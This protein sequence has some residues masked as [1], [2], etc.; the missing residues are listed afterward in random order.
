MDRVQHPAYYQANPEILPL[1]AKLLSDIGDGHVIVFVN[2]RHETDRVARTLKAN[3]IDAAML[4]GSVPQRKRQSLLRRFRENEIDVLV[5]TDV[6]ARGLHIPD[7]IGRASC[8]ER[9]KRRAGGS[10]W[11]VEDRRI[12]EK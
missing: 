1:L 3:G 4:A 2:T 7:E 11:R 6:A 5:A 10:C 8:R 9:A 12:C